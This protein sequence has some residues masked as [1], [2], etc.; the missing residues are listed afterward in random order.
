MRR[1]RR[2]ARPP[3]SQLASNFVIAGLASAIHLHSKTRDARVTRGHD[4]REGLI[5]M[6]TR[7]LTCALT[8]GAPIQN[9]PAVPI[10]PE[11]IAQQ[12]ID[13][14]K[15]GAAIAHIHVRDP[16]TGRSSMELDLYREVVGRIRDSG[17]DIV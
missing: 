13:P 3:A 7:I 15:T 9:N 10:T 17:S 16:K 1:W 8:G 14:G 2:R 4:D 12:A 5:G 6:A 11:Q